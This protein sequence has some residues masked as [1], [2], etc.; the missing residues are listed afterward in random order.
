VTWLGARSSRV[1]QEPAMTRSVARTA[2]TAVVAL[3]TGLAATLTV[4]PA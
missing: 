1:P 2:R 3:L 4:T